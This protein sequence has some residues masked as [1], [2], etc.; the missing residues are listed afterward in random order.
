VLRSSRH[1]SPP[2]TCR[3][4]EGCRRAVPR[5]LQRPKGPRTELPFV[6]TR[7]HCSSRRRICSTDL[8]LS[9]FSGAGRQEYRR[10]DGSRFKRHTLR[11]STASTKTGEWV[12]AITCA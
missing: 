4:C 9:L 7:V 5:L 2:L 6:Q 12:V 11:R 10:P 3:C 1:L 8:Q